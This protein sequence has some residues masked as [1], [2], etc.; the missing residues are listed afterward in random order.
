MQTKLP[1]FEI[2][3]GH[4][5]RLILFKDDSFCRVNSRIRNLYYQRVEQKTTTSN[6]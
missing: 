2:R 4:R 5:R 3:N 1:S 6:R